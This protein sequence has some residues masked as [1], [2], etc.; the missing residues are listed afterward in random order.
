MRTKLRSLRNRARCFLRS[1]DCEYCPGQRATHKLIS[2]I[3]YE[4]TEAPLLE[5]HCGHLSG[6]NEAKPQP[7]R[8]L[9]S[10][11][12]VCGFR[13]LNE[14]RQDVNQYQGHYEGNRQLL[15]M[16]LILHLPQV[17]GCPVDELNEL[18]CRRGAEST[19]G[20]PE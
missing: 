15:R 18:I 20:L 3:D 1:P 8:R 16:A 19:R 5:D 17:F 2:H 4:K 10:S 7:K 14:V 11:N 13:V 6:H 12:R 9:N